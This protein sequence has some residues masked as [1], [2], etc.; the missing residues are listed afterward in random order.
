MKLQPAVVEWWMLT[1]TLLFHNKR[2]ETLSFLFWLLEHEKRNSLTL[3]RCRTVKVH[4][5]TGLRGRHLWPVFLFW[6]CDCCCFIYL[7][8]GEFFSPQISFPSI[9]WIFSVAVW[10]DKDPATSTFNFVLPRRTRCGFFHRD[11]YYLLNKLL[12]P[13]TQMQSQFVAHV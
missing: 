8:A 12:F 4:Q 10:E 9:Y 13:W 6:M 1:L 3:H 11:T 5:N 7:T 2:G